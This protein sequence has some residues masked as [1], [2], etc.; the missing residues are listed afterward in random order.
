M[1]G[2][3]GPSFGKAFGHAWGHAGVAQVQP[4]RG[5]G[6]LQ[7]LA[8]RM[9]RPK[10]ARTRRERERDDLLVLSRP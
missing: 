6:Y 4:P 3:W 8:F 10:L 9:P 7:G 2:A 1:S 5:A